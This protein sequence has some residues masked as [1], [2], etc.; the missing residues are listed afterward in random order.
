MSARG[1]DGAERLLALATAGLAE[2]RAEWGAAMRAELAAIEPPEE[3]RR[4]ARGAAWAAYR[5]GFHRWIVGGLIAAVLVAAVALAAS[6]LQLPHGR[7]GVLAVTSSVPAL[8]LLLVALVCAARSRSFR[9]GVLTGAISIILSFLALTVVLG[10][11]GMVW[12]DRH[13]VFV[14]DADPPKGTAAD[15]TDIMLD[16]FTTGM[17]FVHAIPWIAGALVGTALGWWI[18]HNAHRSRADHPVRT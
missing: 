7:P 17:W 2:D 4:F 9:A 15:R 12:M 3:R 16:I 6:R 8:L 18:G 14:L 13:G 5:E 11:E 10:V 1:R